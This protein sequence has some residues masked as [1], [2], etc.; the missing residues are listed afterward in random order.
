MPLAMDDA[1]AADMTM[2]ALGKELGEELPGMLGMQTVQI[3]FQ[4]HLDRAALQVG[5]HPAL[6][7]GAGKQEKVMRFDFG[8]GQGNARRVFWRHDGTRAWNGRRF[9]AIGRDHIML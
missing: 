4:P 6:N 8:F 5:E 1:R 2:A 7:A 9:G 3:H